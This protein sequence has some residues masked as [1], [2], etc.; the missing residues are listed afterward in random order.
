MNVPQTHRTL[1]DRD[2]SG[3]FP[4]ANSLK[5]PQAY[6]LETGEAQP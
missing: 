3:P 4:A 6:L 2:V 1:A 5:E